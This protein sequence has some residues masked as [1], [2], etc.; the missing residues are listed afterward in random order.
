MAPREKMAV[1]FA[2]SRPRQYAAPVMY[3]LAVALLALWLVQIIAPDELPTLYFESELAA[4]LVSDSIGLSTLLLV[5]F[6]WL[7]GRRMGAN[8]ALQVLGMNPDK[9]PILFLR[10]FA[11]DETK[12]TRPSDDQVLYGALRRIAP[13][14][15]FGDPARFLAHLG[16]P[17][18]YMEYRDDWIDVVSEKMRTSRLVVLK[19]G[20]TPGVIIEARQTLA[21]CRPEQ[22][23]F[24]MSIYLKPKEL[25]QLYSEFSDAI[26]DVLP[27]PLP[28]VEE[29]D[30]HRCIAFGEDGRPELIARMRKPIIWWR[31]WFGGPLSRPFV[32]LYLTWK[33]RRA[34]RPARWRANGPRL[35]S[36]TSSLSPP[37]AAA[38]R[39]GPM[40]SS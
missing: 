11:H 36:S 12:L 17:R 30:N 29:L 1:W 28:P 25:Q 35:D 10:S 34:M 5:L 7:I 4:I 22:I 33:M 2:N 15:T 27:H 32:T 21:I 26:A 37:T 6:F 39:T 16:P 9:A 24:Y 23:L 40:S 38:N 13:T 8:T 14:I 20:T 19:V 18:L 31:Y 3:F